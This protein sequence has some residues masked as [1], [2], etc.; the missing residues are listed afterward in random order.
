MVVGDAKMGRSVTFSK[1]M[2]DEL[3]VRQSLSLSEIGRMHG[4]GGTTVLYWLKKYGIQRRPAC[5][6][7]IDVSKDVLLDLYWRKRWSPRRI[8]KQLG[9][10]NERTVRKKMATYGIPRRTQS[11]AR[12]VKFRKSFDGTQEERAYLLGLRAGDF[13][14]RKIRSNTIRMQTSTTHPAQVQLLHDALC[15]YGELRKYRYKP[16]GRRMEWFIYV[17]LDNSFEFLLQKP[18][19]IPTWA[20]AD[21]KCF[22]A[23]LSAYIDCEG[24]W[25][26]S[27]THER[28]RCTFRLRSSDKWLLEEIHE[29]LSRTDYSPI[30]HLERNKGSLSGYGRYTNDFFGII[31]NR[32]QDVLRLIRLV[33]PQ[34]KHD[35]K[36]LQMEFILENIGQRYDESIEGWKRIRKKIREERLD[37]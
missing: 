11:E 4:L 12:I 20:L 34:C 25:H 1:E 6:K 24:N 21:E 8:A 37:E 31:L 18:E 36:R 33:S 5:Q 28:I 13:H 17:D 9:F 32:Q 23:F 29:E 30:L 7:R 14:A 10:A 26:V 19:R 22:A 3:Y 16:R 27:R 15:A 35:E 2:L